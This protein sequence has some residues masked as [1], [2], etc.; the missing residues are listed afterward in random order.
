MEVCTCLCAVHII[1]SK[2]QPW[3]WTFRRQ[4]RL[5]GLP[6][7]RLCRSN[8]KFPVKRM[9]KG[10]RKG[11]R[12]EGLINK[13][14][15]KRGS[16]KLCHSLRL[17]QL[18]C[19]IFTGH[20]VSADQKSLLTKTKIN[21]LRIIVQPRVQYFIRICKAEVVRSTYPTWLSV[22]FCWRGMQLPTKAEFVC[23]GRPTCC[24]FLA[25]DWTESGS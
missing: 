22:M 5:S 17:H 1:R 12:H 13:K 11:V 16:L 19:L 23:A 10:D 24:C 3:R 8:K 20:M 21:L 2:T 15:T 9:R 25:G 14:K 7:I 4:F 18:L 6:E